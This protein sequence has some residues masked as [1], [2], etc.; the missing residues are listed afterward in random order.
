MLRSLSIKNIA[1]VDS[2]ELAF[3]PGMTVIT[4]ETGAGK[5]VL[6]NSLSLI[7]GERADKEYIRHG[8]E[9][10]FIEAIFETNNKT[11]FLTISRQ[12]SK[13]GNSKIGV[14]KKHKLQRYGISIKRNEYRTK[15]RV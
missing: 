14:F 15:Q 11:E 6:V 10:A 3:D 4:G 9:S 13:N 2:L 5:S 8:S 1:L 7:L 12:I